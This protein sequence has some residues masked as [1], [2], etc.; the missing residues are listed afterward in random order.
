M[1]KFYRNQLLQVI[2]KLKLDDTLFDIIESEDEGYYTT[3]IDLVGS[4]L[5]FTIMETSKSFH[6]FSYKYARNTPQITIKGYP[7]KAFPFR[8]WSKSPYKFYK[9]NKVK[10]K[11]KYW[12]KVELKDF[13]RDLKEEDLWELRM[14]DDLLIFDGHRENDRFEYFNDNEQEE[15]Y[16]AL[17]AARGEIK[18]NVPMNE[19]ELARINEKIDYLMESVKKL[20]KFDWKSV[21]LSSVIDIVSDLTLDPTGGKMVFDIIRRAFSNFPKLLG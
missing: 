20:N 19:E 18:E 6:L 5:K 16:K 12:L 11:F 13:F 15:V 10:S 8:R 21:L 14:Q 7:R 2:D 9:F 17:N 1:Q 4:G 3:E